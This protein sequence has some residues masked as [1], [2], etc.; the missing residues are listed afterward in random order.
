MKGQTIFKRKLNMATAE[1]EDVPIY[2]LDGKEVS[3]E[4]FEIE[5]PLQPIIV[6][7]PYK[8][9]HFVPIESEALAYHPKQ[10]EEAKAYFKKIGIGDTQINSKGQPILR[11]RQHRRRVLRALGKIDRASFSGY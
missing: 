8:P 10:I 9:C 7:E 4:E 2:L 3:R 5:F 11:D 6:G 1:F